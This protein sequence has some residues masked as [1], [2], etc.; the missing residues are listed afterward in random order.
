ML[1]LAAKRAYHHDGGKFASPLLWAEYI[2]ESILG[3]SQLREITLEVMIYNDFTTSDW[4]TWEAV[5]DILGRIAVSLPELETVEIKHSPPYDTGRWSYFQGRLA[6]ALP[7]VL[8]ERKVLVF[9]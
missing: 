4:S 3:L 6:F 7:K 8:K 2:L 9:T 5:G 1:N